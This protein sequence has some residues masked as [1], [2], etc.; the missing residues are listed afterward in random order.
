MQFPAC[1]GC[2]HPSKLDAQITLENLFKILGILENESEAQLFS[3]AFNEIL[4]FSFCKNS[5]TSCV[6]FS[7]ISDEVF[8]KII[9]GAANHF[10]SSPMTN[11]Q[12]LPIHK[13]LDGIVEVTVCKISDNNCEKFLSDDYDVKLTANNVLES[14]HVGNTKELAPF[15][16]DIIHNRVVRA[17]CSLECK[18]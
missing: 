4:N 16:L 11:Y 7:E 13:I 1:P 10:K 12:I 6:N 15:L 8:Q 18:P 9:F 2:K 5:T 17:R 3:E 14:L